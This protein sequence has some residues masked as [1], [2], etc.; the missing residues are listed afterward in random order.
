MRIYEKVL[1]VVQSLR[2][3]QLCDP[4]DCSTPDFPVLHHLPEF[5]QI[6]V[7]WAGDD[8]QPTYILSFPFALAL[9]FS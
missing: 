1:A 5:P 8:I 3:I 6:H 2:P 7:H 9:N 4:L